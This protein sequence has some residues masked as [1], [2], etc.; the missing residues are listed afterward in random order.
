[1]ISIKNILTRSLGIQ[2]KSEEVRKLDEVQ[3]R[4]LFPMKISSS[5]SMPALP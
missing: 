2:V 1:M 3:I 5:Q 4:R